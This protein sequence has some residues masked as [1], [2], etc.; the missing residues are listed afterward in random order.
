MTTQQIVP[1]IGFST[2]LAEDALT[3]ELRDPLAYSNKRHYVIVRI[4]KKLLARLDS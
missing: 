3:P 4:L 1:A 2:M